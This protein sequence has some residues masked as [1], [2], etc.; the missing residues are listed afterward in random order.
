MYNISESSSKKLLIGG[1]IVK[2]SRFKELLFFLIKQDEYIPAKN[3]AT[4][5]NVS[6]RTIYN[7]LNDPAFKQLL[8]GAH[9][10][11]K[12]KSGVKLIANQ[13]QLNEIYQFLE[14]DKQTSS[15]KYTFNSEVIPALLLL[16]QTAQPI[17][18]IELANQL[19][20]SVSSLDDV[21]NKAN[22]WIS[23]FNVKIEKRK[24]YG[25]L[26][27]GNEIDIR[28]AYS[29]VCLHALQVQEEKEEAIEFIK[30]LFGDEI[31]EKVSMIVR[32]SE[33]NLDNAYT[34][35]DFLH[36]VIKLC[37]LIVRAKLKRSIKSNYSF[38]SSVRE[39]LV[40]ELVKIQLEN[41]FH[42]SLSKDELN[43]ITYYILS[44][45][46]QINHHQSS[47]DQSTPKVVDKFTT[48]LSERLGL[49]LSKDKE[50]KSNLIAHL[51]PAIKR[52]RY[53]IKID[54]PLLNQIKYEYTSIYIAVM[55]TIEEIEQSEQIAFDANELGY[56]C[57]HIVAAINRKKNN[58]SFSAC[59]LCDAG[60]TI[61]T[62]LKSK[63]E[64]QFKEISIALIIPSNGFSEARFHSFDIIFNSTNQ[65]VTS[66]DNEI[67]VSSLFDEN[68]QN[69]IRSWILKDKYEK[70]VSR[71]NQFQ[72]N[73]L[74]FKEE[75]LTREELIN[76]YASFLEI[77]GYVSPEFKQSIYDRE[78]RASTAVGKGVAVPHGSGAF[79]KKSIILAIPLEES[80]IWEEH[81]VDF[82]L[83]IAIRQDDNEKYRFFFERL[84]QL[85]SD[86]D[87]LQKIKNATSAQ[88]ISDILF[89]KDEDAH[90]VFR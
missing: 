44:A 82:V 76:K 27:N 40:A 89:S 24:N 19:Y 55:T 58:K 77:E 33:T 17:Q 2:E 49:D 72:D 53:G 30:T 54:N 43:E 35:Y 28:T 50:L 48:I 4:C 34:R 86:I 90:F 20:V 81:M 87:L 25:I 31:V 36:L 45:R 15:Q 75:D 21:L 42:L 3:I 9:I 5:L 41:E 80:I 70:M 11:K 1:F 12:Q 59:L 8:K 18:S 63:I 71:K 23:P 79:V 52:L 46:L 64:N 38:S 7:D 84:Y 69:N 47:N 56:I 74:F 10:D 13:S 16:F 37:V 83:F 73:I 14:D 85:F 60:L 66:K 65:S 57:L 22:K 68:D 39:F 88:E 67:F 26:L 32:K 62:Y 29:S 6:T 78:D 51:D 61:S